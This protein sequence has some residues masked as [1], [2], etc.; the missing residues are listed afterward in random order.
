MQIVVL[1]NDVEDQLDWACG[2]DA[3]R[4]VTGA[5]ISHIYTM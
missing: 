2:I 5:W 4:K 1:E 3:L